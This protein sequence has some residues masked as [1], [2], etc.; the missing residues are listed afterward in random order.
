MIIRNNHLPETMKKKKHITKWLLGLSLSY[1]LGSTF[2]VT[3][4]WVPTD[5]MENTIKAKSLIA[6]DEMSY[7]ALLPRRVSEIALIKNVFYL[8]PINLLEYDLCHS[9]GRIRMP[10]LRKPR[11]GDIIV[12][13]SPEDTRLIL[14]K[15]VIAVSGDTLDIRGGKCFV[16]G[17][18]QTFTSSVIPTSESDTVLKAHFPYATRWDKHNYGPIIIPTDQDNPLYF[19]M[20]DNRA[21][22]RDSRAWG[23]VDFKK[24]RGR[25]I[26]S[27]G[28]RRIF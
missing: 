8:L 27:I 19:V 17:V 21:S 3:F 24:I 22:S 13:E 12:F 1:I 20:G 25:I 4:G 11:R 15:R 6:I 10:G 23:Y 28:L 2:V 5:S 14:C 9:W 26:G 16:N 7:G 18:E